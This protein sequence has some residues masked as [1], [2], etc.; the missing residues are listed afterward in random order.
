MPVSVSDP[1]S[2]HPHSQDTHPP[3]HAPTH[4]AP[5][6]VVG[7][8]LASFAFV[9][10]PGGA[11]RV[12][13]CCAHST[14]THT[15]TA[16]ARAGGA[17]ICTCGSALHKWTL[18][19][20]CL[21]LLPGVIGRIPVG[22]R[23]F[24]GKAHHPV[25][26]F[27]GCS[28]IEARGRE[29]RR[30]E[31]GVGMRPCDTFERALS[32]RFPLRKE[33]A[34]RSHAR[35]NTHTQMHARTGTPIAHTSANIRAP[36]LAP[37]AAGPRP[38]IA[39]M[40]AHKTATGRHAL[41]AGRPCSAS[42]PDRSITRIMRRHHTGPHRASEPVCLVATGTWPVARRARTPPV[43]RQQRTRAAHTRARS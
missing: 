20:P 18:G 9:K 5:A 26:R 4:R 35:T 15:H 38:C 37:L 29:S 10:L 24:A 31:L 17:G 7:F 14:H 33:V 30:S 34:P 43:S 21:V 41:R 28:C 36:L 12:T 22:Q 1:T 27:V 42:R 23:I 3:S 16:R 25:W 8:I 32:R 19:I 13:M 39:C 40:H 11:T 6:S 2:Q